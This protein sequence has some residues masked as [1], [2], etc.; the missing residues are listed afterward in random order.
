MR[1]RSAEVVMGLRGI[2]S[3]PLLR[4]GSGRN[5]TPIDREP[6]QHEAEMSLLYGEL[7]HWPAFADDAARKAAWFAHR[8]RL[9]EHCSWG[10]RPAGWWDYECP[11]RRPRDR[12]YQEAALWENGLLTADE[13]AGL[14]ASWRQAFERA[15][16]PGF[17]FRAAA[18]WLDGWRAKK[19][20][21]KWVGV[22]R[23]LIREWTAERRRRRKPVCIPGVE[24]AAEPPAA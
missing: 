13:V 21:L 10:K 19:A 6:L 15:Q 7:R 16:D 2:G 17:A 11:I 1:L 24:S 23:A 12:D 14:E 9:L 5:P 3:H 22:P 18:G 20:Y 8:D 4:R